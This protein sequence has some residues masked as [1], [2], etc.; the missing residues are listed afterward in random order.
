MKKTFILLMSL[1]ALVAANLSAK[2]QEV[3]TA[4]VS[5]GGD[6]VRPLNIFNTDGNWNDGS[7]WSTGV[8]PDPGSDVVIMAHVVIPAGYIAI[9][10]EVSLEGGSITVSDGG[11]LR[12][13]TDDLVVTMK[14]NIEPYSVVN[15]TDNYYLLGFPFSE[16]VAI[17]DDMTA[18]GCD[19]YKFNGDYPNAEWR[20]NRM[21]PITTV[22]DTT[23]Y[24]YAS[25][26]AIEISL[27]GS[28]YP[29]YYGETKTV[30]IPYTE[31]ST[32]LSNGWALLGNPFT[33]DAYLYYYDSENVLVP[34]DFM[35]YDTDGNWVTLNNSPIAPMQ[36]FFVKVTETTTIYIKNYLAFSPYE[37]VDLG[38]PSG[39]L[40]ATCNIGSDA[41]E[42]CGSYFAW[43]ETQT[44][45]I[46]NWSTYQYCNGSNNTLTKYCNDPDYGYNSFSDT[47]TILLPEDDAATANWGS[48]WR[49]PTKDDMQELLSNTTRILTTQNGVIGWLFTASNGNSIFLPATGS[50]SEGN[51]NGV[52]AFGYYLTSSLD[53]DYPYS[54]RYFF[55][56]TNSNASYMSSGSR[57]VGRSVRPVR[58]SSQNPSFVINATVNHNG[59]G[60]IIGGGTYQAGSTCTFTA[61]ANEGFVF[62]NWTEE[63]E[64]VSAEATFSFVV[65]ENRNLVANFGVYCVG[66]YVDLGLPS[67]TLWA[68]CNVGA[69][70]QECYG[71][72]FAW[73][74][75]QSKD[76]YNWSTYQHCMGSENT[77]TKYCNSSD[78]GYN[79]YTD[80]LKYLQSVDDAATANWGEDW[81]TPTMGEW[82]ELFENTTNIWTT[83]NGVKGRL[84]VASNGNSI[85]LPAAG[86]RY[87]S[88]F[89]YVGNYGYYWTNYYCYDYPI[90]NPQAMEVFLANSGSGGS[91]TSSY[92]NGGCSVRAVR[93]SS[94]NPSYTINATAQPIEGGSIIGGGSY[95][96]GSTCT[97]TAVPNEGYVFINWTEDDE[98]VS[99]EATYSFVANENRN[100]VANFGVYCAGTY[101]DLGLPS[102]LL[103]ATCNVGAETQEG[104]G[105]NF[106]WG[107]TQPKDTYYWSNYQHCSNGSDHSLTKYCTY[108]N[109]GY[110]GFTDYLT[111]LLPEDDAAAVNW[112]T[113]WRMPTSAEWQE[114][115]DNTTNTW[116]TQNGVSGY[117]ITASNGNSI[118]LPVNNYESFYWSSSLVAS[119]PSFACEF[120]FD[121]GAAYGYFDEGNR[122]YGRPVRAVRCKNSVINVSSNFSEFGAVSGGGTYFDGTNCTVS[123]TA[124]DG[125]TFI[126][127]VEDGATVSVEATYSFT[128]SGNR[129]LVAYF[130]NY[131]SGA[132]Q[133]VDLGLPS[134][135]LWATCNIGAEAPEG[136]GNYYAWGETQPK[137]T[138]NWSTYQ[139][140]NGSSNTLTKYCNRS[141]YG[142]N[143][144]T[145]NLTTLLPEDD[146]ATANWGED[147]RMPTHEEWQE[148]CNN[149]TCNWTNL[150]GVIGRLFTA[151]NGNSLFLPVAG[152]R[153]G[154]YLSYLGSVG[155]YWSSSLKNYPGDAWSYSFSYESYGYDSNRSYGRSVRAVRPAPQNNV[156]T[157]AIDGKF[158]INADG[159]QVYFSQ[160]NLQ[161]Q[162]STNTWRFADSQYDYVG[163]DNSNI[164]STYSGWIDLFGWGTSGYNH[165]A[166]CYQPWDTSTNYSDYYAYGEYTYNL[167]DQTGKADW[168]YNA[169]NNGGNTE[170]SGWRTLTQPEWTYVF[171]TRVTT[172]GIRYAKA[173][174]NNVN[175]VILLPDD[176]SSSTYSL[177]N[178]NNS[179]A[180][181]SCNT[182]TASQ[183]ST[184]EQAGAVFLPAAGYRYGTSVFDVAGG[185]YWSASYFISYYA[186]NV[187]FGDSYI[188]TD[189]SYYRCSGRSVRLVRVAE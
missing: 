19:F 187:F 108:S 70:A 100:L 162:A 134:G 46:Y 171:N 78:Y 30:T 123:A 118:F 39:T 114:L 34:M 35:V 82:L 129:N 16:E 28:T 135:L 149:T 137:T 74:E 26:E 158:T 9:A 79:G 145:D 155:C 157:G 163:N 156:P 141:S 142:Y 104:Y 31:G 56:R 47:L 128:V 52:G 23:G 44:K 87:E 65:N 181:F 95:Q 125:Y 110:N 178:T 29:S 173:N 166:N 13:N 139:H 98:I 93:S 51:N 177:S 185:Y 175:G 167:Y 122:A 147:W 36:G 172:S 92:R 84:V 169:I 62:I 180:S 131:V 5:K 126:G 55:F 176:W 7:K 140:C 17:P 67:G 77:L 81:R 18:E 143:G 124:N 25:P 120:T 27:T 48:D 121:M 43:G 40:W 109:Y 94:Q 32:N 133:Y 63:G 130:Y 50:F 151:A 183:W 102:G 80:T 3:T 144:F 15:G 88:N 24:L 115:F 186:Y 64:E 12:H 49:M 153:Y 106:A 127:W 168:G 54:A 57:S 112:G 20:N 165:G 111:T 189:G 38:M 150:N 2:A 6:V 119:D 8:V 105:D 10:N 37:Y 41:P 69:E 21:H 75:T 53:T 136:Y 179:G 96:E 89:S 1:V 182:L 164:S 22:G 97:F 60:S 174:V 113:D 59:R 42:N 33:C 86:S 161:Y 138:Y 170:N 159:D 4:E 116:I 58:A 148:L 99:T 160:G 76:I 73:G 66:T 103:W 14:K 184:L 132:Y 45:D 11:Q 154:N 146:A 107:E 152:N 90:M 85:F 91:Y 68:T 101:V 117:F 188:Y 72:Y 71:D 61:T 83:R